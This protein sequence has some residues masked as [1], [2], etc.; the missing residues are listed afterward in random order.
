MCVVGKGSLGCVKTMLS[1]FMDYVFFSTPDLFL[2]E[3]SD[4]ENTKKQV[5]FFPWAPRVVSSGL[6][7]P[8]EKVE[9][10][11]RLLLMLR[12]A[13]FFAVLL[14]VLFLFFQEYN[15]RTVLFVQCA[16]LGVLCIAQGCRIWVGWGWEKRSSD[17]FE[18]AVGKKFG[19]SRMGVMMGVVVVFS[20]L[21][22]GMLGIMIYLSFT[23]EVGFPIWTWLLVVSMIL[24]F[25][26]TIVWIFPGLKGAFAD[27]TK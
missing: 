8:P 15:S 7:V 3:V 24:S 18:A 20:L 10:L 2:L 9:P 12:F 14:C 21:F 22:V 17:D 25:A 5:L 4:V 23:K 26:W 11:R 1:S 16:A 6:V 19:K 27:K 13:D